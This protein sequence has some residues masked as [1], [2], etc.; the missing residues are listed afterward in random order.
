MFLDK[1]LF[2][3]GSGTYQFQYGQYQIKELVT[4]ISTYKGD[5]GNAHSDYFGF[6]SE[7]GLIG[8]LIFLSMIFSTMKLGLQNIYNQDSKY[9]NLSMALLLGLTTFF[10]EGL[11]NSFIDT[12][13]I[14]MLVFCGMAGL[15]AI[16]LH[17]K[18]LISS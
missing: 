7:T 10:I 3:F 11:F 5:K 13:K 1:P 17:N 18:K 14:M 16:D 8:L 6:L 2:G 15:V 9:K 12:D 4:R